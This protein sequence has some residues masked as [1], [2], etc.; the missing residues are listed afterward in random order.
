ME[1]SSMRR[2]PGELARDNFRILFEERDLSHPE[3]IWAEDAVDHVIATGESVRGRAALADWFR[4]LFAAA[5][6]WKIEIEH[7]IDDG[8]RHAVV[9]WRGSGTLT[10]AAFQG[11]E[12]TGKRVELRGVD[13]MTFG[14]DGLVREN[15][16]YYDGAEFARQLG[17]LPPR[18][19]ALDRG[20]V[21]GFNLQTR[22]RS[23]FARHGDRETATTT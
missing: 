22:L 6:D 18:G 11:I 23:R 17:M 12:P 7:V 15:T 4:T 5:P 10:G 19:S 3:R 9:Q 14:D 13:V 2:S 21:A 8:E 16:V 1:S 20:L